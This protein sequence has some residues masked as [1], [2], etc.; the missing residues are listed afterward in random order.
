MA[1][2]EMFPSMPSENMAHAFLLSSATAALILLVVTRGRLG[3]PPVRAN[4]PSP[5]A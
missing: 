2:T 4:G 3:C 5:S 1:W